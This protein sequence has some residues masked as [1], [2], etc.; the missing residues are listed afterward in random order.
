MKNVTVKV[1]EKEF[2]IKI[3]D[4]YCDK[5]FIEMILVKYPEAKVEI[6]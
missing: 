6:K 3:P 1:N 5:E 4:K 2:T